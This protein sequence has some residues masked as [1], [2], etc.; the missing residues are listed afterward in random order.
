MTPHIGDRFKLLGKEWRVSLL[1][2]QDGTLEA[3]VNDTVYMYWPL[4]EV[5]AL[6]WIK[7]EPKCSKEFAE[8]LKLQISMHGHFLVWLDAHTES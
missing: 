6:D 3:L 4:S 2:P 1:I 8:A 5:D 7:P